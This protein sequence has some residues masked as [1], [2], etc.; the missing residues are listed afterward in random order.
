MLREGTPSSWPLVGRQ[1]ELD[2]IE[3]CRARVEGA[4]V[5]A[6]QAGVG[7]S[8]LAREALARFSRTGAQTCWVQ[9]T[10]S[11]ASVPLGAFTGVLPDSVRPENPLE[12]L[13]LAAKALR[14]SGRLVPGIDDAHLLDPSSAALV[15]E[16]TA[17][18]TVFVVLTVRSAGPCP[19]ATA[20]I[21]KDGGATRLELA[22][23]DQDQTESLAEEIAGGA[24]EQSARRWIYQ[25]SLGNALYV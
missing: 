13:R 1:G 2:L 15:L 11:A 19:D 25:T 23:L 22:A 20:S 4:V 16:P 14:G 9:A 21:W 17:S 10:H 12:L 8:G 6:G 7:K 18:A 3:R 5:L 24:I